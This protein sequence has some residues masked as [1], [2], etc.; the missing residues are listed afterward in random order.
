[1]GAGREASGSRGRFDRFNIYTGFDASFDRIGRTGA[2]VGPLVARDWDW[3]G[4]RPGGG[5]LLNRRGGERP[6]VVFDF[7]R[8]ALS[9][10]VKDV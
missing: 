7:F 2:A 4:L 6:I 5:G 1:M 9:L 3:D 8:L 10:S